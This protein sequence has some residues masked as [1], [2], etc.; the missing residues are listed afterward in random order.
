MSLSKDKSKRMIAIHGW[1][2][3]ALGLLLYVVILTGAVAVFASEIGKWTA[4]GTQASDPLDRPLDAALRSLGATIN[5]D[6][7]EEITVSSNSSGEIVAFFHTHA[8]HEETGEP[9]DVGIM[10][11]LD[12]V[13]LDVLRQYEGFRSDMPHDQVGALDEFIVDMHVNLHIPGR[14]GLY[15][16]G[17]LGLMMMV[18]TVSGILIHKHLIKDIFVSARTSSP[19]LTRRDNHNLAATWSIPFAFILAF[20]GSFFSFAGTLALPVVAMINFGGDQVAM[21]ETIVGKPLPPDE[22]PA[23]L[24]NIDDMVAHSSQITGS[25]PSFLVISHWGQ[26]DASVQVGHPPAS[27]HLTRST[28]LFSGATGEYR[29]TKPLIGTE[30]SA[31]GVLLGWMGPLHFGNFQGLLSKVIWFALGI[32]MAYVTLTGLQLWVQRRREAPVWAFFSRVITTFGYGTAT[33]MAGAGIG[34]FL[35]LPHGAAIAWTAWGF[36]LTSA[37]CLA[38]GAVVLDEDRLGDIMK[39]LLGLSL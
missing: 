6:Y 37:L 34:F 32:A 8:V 1:A 35:A 2:G 33:A 11:Y 5:P 4:G 22:T 29:G 15:A 39:G 9:G 12:P 21:I 38:I 3:V 24:A 36:I 13:S 31:G 19:V 17:I 7:L 27:G 14:W 18:A 25:S 26:A 10:F 28:H 20:T 16:T 23:G 30:E